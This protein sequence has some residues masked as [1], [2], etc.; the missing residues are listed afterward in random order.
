[1]VKVEVVGARGRV[2]D[3]EILLRSLQHLTKGE[4]VPL[5]ADLVCGKDHLISAVFHAQRAF[6]RGVNIC[7]SMLVETMLY[8]SGERQ[9]SKATKKIGVKRG[10]DKVA[11]VLFDVED[12]EAILRGLQL[13]RDDDVLEASPEKAIRFGITIEEIRAVPS[14]KYGDL[15]LER[16]AFVGLSK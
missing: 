14:D 16:V 6:E 7:S 15:V 4:G 1:M 10:A 11:L 9:I 13:T 8:A 5:D 12:T 3:T 2:D